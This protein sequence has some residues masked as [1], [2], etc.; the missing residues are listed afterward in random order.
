MPKKDVPCEKVEE[1]LFSECASEEAVEA[2]L[3]SCASCREYEEA[4][5][6]LAPLAGGAPMPTEFGIE[7]MIVRA[8]EE[9]RLVMERRA[10]YRLLAVTL[11]ALPG[12]LLLNAFLGWLGYGLIALFA[13]RWQPY[14]LLCLGAWILMGMSLSYGSLPILFGLCHQ[15]REVSDE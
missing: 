11:L 1:A 14:L 8:Q 9:L 2:H 10:F 7:R 13:P 15:G 4:C 3:A 6:L 5:R 12:V